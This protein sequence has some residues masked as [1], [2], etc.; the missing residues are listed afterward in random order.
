LE[1]QRFV[2][3]EIVQE[4]IVLDDHSLVVAVVVAG[5]TA[6]FIRSLLVVLFDPCTTRFDRFDQ[7]DPDRMERLDFDGQLL[8]FFS[9]EEG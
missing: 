5:T 8:S 2:V 7:L 9:Y 6:L 1:Q 4:I 3:L